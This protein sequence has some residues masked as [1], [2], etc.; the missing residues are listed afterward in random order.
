MLDDFIGIDLDDRGTYG[1]MAIGRISSSDV[2]SV[3]PGTV[4]VKRLGEGCGLSVHA[5]ADLVVSMRTYSH[6]ISRLSIRTPNIYTIQPI[7]EDNEFQ[8]WVAEEYIPGENFADLWISPRLGFEYKWGLVKELLSAVFAIPELD[9]HLDILGIKM[10]LMSI[11]LDLKP[12]NIVITDPA[13]PVLVDTYPPVNIWSGGVRWYDPKVYRFE[14]NKLAIVCAT[15]IGIVLRL[16]WLLRRGADSINQADVD[17]HFVDY[18]NSGQVSYD[19][20]ETIVRQAATGFPL[21]RLLY[22]QR[23]DRA[24]PAAASDR[25]GENP[26]HPT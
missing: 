20:A 2:E 12:A 18:L 1:R 5:C 6:E 17:L 7:R 21:L 22:S 8:L 16:W 23:S 4:L 25:R 10:K 13:E 11:G 26:C 15:R 14:H 3:W 24:A 9:V 19:D